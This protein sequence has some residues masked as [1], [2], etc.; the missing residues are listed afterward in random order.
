MRI[1]FLFSL[2][3]IPNIAALFLAV[4]LSFSWFMRGA[5]LCVVVVCLLLPALVLKAR[6]Y[7]IV[8]GLFNFLFFPI[9]IASLY[10]NKQPT[11]LPFLEVIYHTNAKEG[12]EFLIS[13]W[14]LCLLVVTLWVIYFVMAIRME[15]HYL[16]GSLCRKILI[17]LALLIPCTG[18]TMMSIYQWRA[19][20]ERSFKD[21]MG[22]ALT[23]VSLKFHKVYPYNLFI[24]SYLTLHNQKRIRELQRETSQFTFG[25]SQR[26]DKSNPIYMLVIGEASR[27]DH[28]GINH[29]VRN[30]TPL[31]SHCP[32]L[33][34][35]EN[36]YTQANRTEIALPILLTRATITNF[37]LAYSE[38]SLPEAFQEAGYQTGYISKQ[39][40]FHL[41]ERI[42]QSCDFSYSYSKG[43]DTDN[44]YDAEMLI[45][46]IAS[47]D[48][49]QFYILH[50]LGSHFRYEQRY[51]TAFNRYM[52]V[53]GRSAS[54]SLLTK[55]NKEKLINAYDNS[56]L[57]TDF[58]LHEL[59]QYIDSTNRPAVIVYISDHG[60]SFWDDSRNLSFHCSYYASE[61][62]FHV[63]LIVWY[64]DE[65]KKLHPEKVQNLLQN[66][67]KPMSSDVIFNSLMDLAGIEDIVDSTKSICSSC[68]TA[69]DTIHMMIGNGVIKSMT[70]EELRRGVDD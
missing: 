16:F 34:S 47:I 56:I 32:N 17:V 10:L 14:P 52:P 64:S 6:T 45:P 59:I 51:P 37:D 61:A 1:A 65:Y 8:E 33:I 13:I 53:L 50:T 66:K 19:H 62:E 41:T 58:V 7:F 48:S 67:V 24:H 40:L 57:Y 26:Q 5:Y 68:L 46:L 54:Y 63:P 4:D 9:E 31:L 11:S 23:L 70:I 36:V 27:Y 20:G 18:I 35:Y 49:L 38:K 39:T 21:N 28:W 12:Y 3:L 69:A 43:L 25:I 55:E 42:S 15:N 22:T 44:N 60:E 30:T 29:Y 2:L